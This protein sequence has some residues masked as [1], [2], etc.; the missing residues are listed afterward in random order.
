MSLAFGREFLSI[1]GPGVIPDAV[2]Q[3]MHRPAVDIYEGGALEEVTWTLLSDLKPVARTQGES[4]IYI[5]NGHAAWEAALANTLSRGDEILVLESGRFA[6]GWGQMAQSM[7]VGMDILPAPARRA[8]DPN[9]VED[10]LRAD[11]KHRIKAV[12]CVQVDTAS[13]L[14]NDI[15][16]IRQAIDAAG[17][18]ALFMVDVIASQG[19]MRYEMDAWGVDVTV[20]GSQKGLMTPPGLG[21]NWA[22]EKALAAGQKADLRTQYWD[23]S[24]RRER[25]HYRKYCGTAPIHM[26]FALRAALDILNAEGLENA[27]KRHRTH[28]NAVRA[29][30]SAWAEGGVLEMNPIEP[31]ERADS[32]TTVL[33]GEVDVTRL[34]KFCHEELGL[35]LGRGIGEFEGKA[36]RIGH[37]G[38][39]N[40]PMILGTLASTQ[41]GLIASQIPHGSGALEAAAA[42]IAEHF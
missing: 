3:A 22:N 38:H 19:C 24:L 23:W 20:G 35:V 9:A 17:H 1:P 27:W 28:A 31:A 39:L 25:P 37:M 12:L 7:G 2:L 32:V 16:A 36:F 4:F 29:A 42:A 15:A 18:P 14:Y 40:P 13:S 10:R 5:G 21:F 30:V 34:R 11:T 41:V 8:I 6:V 33:T 26:I